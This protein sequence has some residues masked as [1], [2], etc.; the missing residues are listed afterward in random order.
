MG[1]C[2]PTIIVFECSSHHD[3]HSIVSSK[4]THNSTAQ[5]STA[6]HSRMSF[7]YWDGEGDSSFLIF[8]MTG[9]KKM[10]QH[11]RQHT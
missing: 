8:T 3:R 6:Q 7:S 1:W 11:S 2:L 4:Q 10:F 9:Y 5:H